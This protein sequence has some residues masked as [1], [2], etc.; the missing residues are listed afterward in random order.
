[1]TAWLDLFYDLVFVAAILILSSAVSHAHQTARVAWIVAVFASLWWIWLQTTLFI[2]RFRVDDM[3]HRVLVL[4]QM[5]LVILVAMEAHEGVVRDGACI[6]LMYAA[7]IGTVAVMYARVA[8]TDGMRTSYA[9]SRMY[10]LG[11]STA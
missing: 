8:R 11:A 2:N 10:F 7:L 4:A 5:F 6:S 3:T 1:M 9:A